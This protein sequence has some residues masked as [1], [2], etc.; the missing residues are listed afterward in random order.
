MIFISVRSI[1]V[2]FINIINKVQ[3]YVC[4]YV[5]GLTQLKVVFIIMYL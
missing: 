4:M 1:P 2:V 5:Y 3:M